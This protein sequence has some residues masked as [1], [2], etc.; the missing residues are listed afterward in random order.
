MLAAVLLLFGVQARGA[1][2]FTQPAS[3]DAL[4]RTVLAR[5]AARLANA[6][7]LRGQFRHNR[8]VPELPRPLAS[9]GEFV[10]ARDLGVW[11]HTRQ[12]F[13]SVIVLTEA[14]M[15]QSDEGA[16]ATRVSADEQPAVRL[17]A[18][19]FSSLFSLDVKRLEKEFELHG[20]NEGA[21]WTIGLKPRAGTVSGA[22][23]QIIVAGSDDVEQV[24]LGDA[25]GDRTVIDL[26]DIRYSGAAPD[27]E[28]RALFSQPR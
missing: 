25:Q 1:D 16:P 7:V 17:I 21:R 22:I 20:V 10:F 2:P 19:I 18:S 4:L 8:H 28:T 12:P 23:G 14:G 3:A 15:S 26:S 11:W 9:N 27:A 6:Q 13:N 5:P 24:V